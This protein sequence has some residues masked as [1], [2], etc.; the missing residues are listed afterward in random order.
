[1]MP[2]RLGLL[3]AGMLSLTVRPARA[4]DPCATTAGTVSGTVA[5]GGAPL[6]GARVRVQGCLGEPVL[7]DAG[8][9]FTLAVP[10]GDVIV[11]AAADGYFIGCAGT[12]AGSCSPVQAG[13]TGLAITLDALATDDP[14]YGFREPTN[15]LPCHQDIVDQWGRSTKAHTNR[16]LWVDN[17]YNGNDITASGPPP[18]PVHPP[19]YAF[20]KRHNPEDPSRPTRFG[21]C[22]NCHQPE[23]VGLD[24]TNSNYN[25]YTSADRHGVGCDFCHRIVDVDTSPTGL[26]RPN[27]VDGK[28]TMLRTPSQP[29]LVLGPLDDVT[30]NQDSVMRA[31][32]ASVLRSSRLCATCHED[33]ADPQDTHG[34][35][36]G[37][38]TGPASQTTYSEWLASDF[39]AQGV[40]CQDCHMPPSGADKLCNVNGASV[41]RDQSQVRSH[42]FEGT[43]PDFLRRAVKLRSFAAVSGDT[44]T[45]DVSIT[46][47]GAGHAVPTGVTLRHL[48]LLVTATERGGAAL[49]YLDKDKNGQTV[50][51]WGGIGDLAA[52]N[53]AG[54]PG[55]GFARVLVDNRFFAENVLF[56]DATSAF[57]N[58][59]AAGATDSSSYHFALPKNWRKRD[60]RVDT[61]LY[62]RRAFKPLADER[63][64]NRPVE[65]G[66]PHG[67]RG[68]GTDYDENFVMAEARSLLT[69]RGKLAK[70]RVTVA[71]GADTAEVSATLTPPRGTTFVPQDSGVGVSLGGADQ[72]AA[73][74]ERVSGFTVDGRTSTLA[75]TTGTIKGLSFTRAGRG[76]RMA[77]RLP[78]TALVAGKPTLG[79]DGGEVCFRKA[80]RCKAK[81]GGLA[82]R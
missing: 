6:A 59:I 80:L 1:M 44:L 16:N 63:H 32:H 37:T 53:F 31:G 76:F 23:Y 24:P 30:F 43:T 78:A 20:L 58:R 15:C 64:W 34:N 51:N 39:A 41:T 69:C 48:I 36:T 21:E 14:S 74:Q 82:C 35:F 45:V 57:D 73:L 27:L 10:A 38:F 13:A 33:S 9:A 60:V 28:T 70:L 46:N 52:G 67:T 72:A 71:A 8:G 49:T 4:A 22:A 17:L 50:P 62:Y 55:K 19:F 3:L 61:Q 26:T 5:G 66:N 79:I 29:G 65:G 47:D 75:T 25:A 40:Q 7:T 68:D 77:L 42:T 18:D 81:R 54:Q 2:A 12:G 11:T 56:T